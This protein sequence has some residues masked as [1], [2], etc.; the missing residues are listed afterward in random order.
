MQIDVRDL[1]QAHILA[2]DN[3]HVANHRVI[4]GGEPYSTQN[5]VDVLKKHTEFAHRLP[6]KDEQAKPDTELRFGDVKEWNSKLGLEL[7]TAEETF[8][9]TARAL[10]E[11]EG[12]LEGKSGRL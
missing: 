1:A 9:D 5:C 3:P 6:K 2:L 10:V 12:K 4:V 7:R 11:L 8:V